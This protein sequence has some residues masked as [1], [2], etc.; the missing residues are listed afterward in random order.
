MAESDV[1]LQTAEHLMRVVERAERI[2]QQL[3]EATSEAAG[4][5]KDLERVMKEARAQVDEYTHEQIK[6]DLQRFGDRAFAEVRSIGEEAIEKT[7]AM[8]RRLEER[9][10]ETTAHQDLVNEA[11][12]QVAMLVQRKFD[13]AGITKGLPGRAYAIEFKVKPPPH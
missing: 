5:I 13:E 4:T 7:N 1:A 6:A 12:N 11:A 10:S 8:M 3:R 2:T 9:L